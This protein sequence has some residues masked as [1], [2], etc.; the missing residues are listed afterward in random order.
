MQQQEA[1]L[2]RW[3]TVDVGGARV[4][5]LE[6]DGIPLGDPVLFLPGWGLTARAYVA[7]LVPLVQ[8]GLRVIAPSLPGFGTS[9]PLG[10]GAPLAAYARRVIELLEVMDPEKP[11]F[12]V[13]HSF[14]GGVAL[15]VAQLR[16]DLI[17][18]VTAVN[19]VGGAPD[20]TGLRRAGWLGWSLATTASRLPRFPR[21][22][23]AQQVARLALDL[24]PNL[25][26]NPLR[27][28]LSG[29]VALTAQLADEA[30]QLADSGMPTLYVWGDRDRL[31]LPGR[32]H[33]LAAPQSTATIA[34]GHGWVITHPKEF[35]ARL[36][37]AL[38][39]HAALEREVRGEPVSAATAAISAAITDPTSPLAE[40]FPLERR[41]RARHGRPVRAPLVPARKRPMDS[42]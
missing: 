10:L 15:K 4:E 11:V 3:R 20:T 18:S 36:H 9:T 33:G 21:A 29:A 34:G 30:R 6:I 17:R 38:A 28:A 2:Q 26:R 42:R 19:P 31:V 16:P 35:A 27:A 5:L 39:M 12:A 41:R 7:A 25:T 8:A 40:L 1:P 22:V 32:L 24:L 23:D 14:G 13:G 37:E